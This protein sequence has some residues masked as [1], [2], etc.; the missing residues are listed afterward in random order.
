MKT[1]YF[2]I[3]ILFFFCQPIYAIDIPPELEK[4]G[5][6]SSDLIKYD[7]KG[8][9]EYF[10]FSNND[11]IEDFS[12]IITFVVIKTDIVDFFEGSK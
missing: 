2:T 10:V 9:V 4:I 12:K 3:L 8:D 1:L 11:V 6:N 7:K 5:F